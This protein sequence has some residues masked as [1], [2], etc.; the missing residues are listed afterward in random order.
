MFSPF[1]LPQL[2]AL[3][4][5]ALAISQSRLRRG[6]TGGFSEDEGA[7]VL[8]T[9]WLSALLIACGEVIS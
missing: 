9:S 8:P 6:G 7:V 2:T 3:S 1:S 5:K 4:P